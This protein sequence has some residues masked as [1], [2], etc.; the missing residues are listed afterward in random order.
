V[1]QAGSWL[2]PRD[3]QLIVSIT[4]YAWIEVAQAGSWYGPRDNQLIVSIT[5]YAW[6]KWR[7]QVA[8]SV[9][10]TISWIV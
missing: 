10:V 5:P 4:P 9:H 3:N 7:M 2:G 6:Y 1:A 8:G